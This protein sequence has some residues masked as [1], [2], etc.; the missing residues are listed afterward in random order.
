MGLLK[1]RERVSE[2]ASAVAAD[3]GESPSL[4]EGREGREGSE[5]KC[6]YV[7]PNMYT[8]PHKIRHPTNVGCE[9]KHS[10]YR[11]LKNEGT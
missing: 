9:E 6:V 11:V 10:F 4:K 7:S 8:F 5:G 3:G 2:R 1:G